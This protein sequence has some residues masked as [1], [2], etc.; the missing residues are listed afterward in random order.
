MVRVEEKDESDKLSSG[1][2]RV[3]FCTNTARIHIIKDN[4]HCLNLLKG[5]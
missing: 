2:L 5:V 1:K 3:V 4:K